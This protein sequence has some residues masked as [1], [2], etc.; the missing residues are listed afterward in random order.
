MQ[1]VKWPVPG[2]P[3]GKL[4]KWGWIYN[5]SSHWAVFVCMLWSARSPPEAYWSLA[6]PVPSIR[7]HLLDLS[8]FDKHWKIMPLEFSLNLADNSPVPWAT[9][10]S[11]RTQCLWRQISPERNMGP[12]SPGKMRGAGDFQPVR[13]TFRTDAQM[14]P[15][16]TLIQ[17]P[18]WYLPHSQTLIVLEE[19][20]RVD[21]C[22]HH[23]SS[24]SSRSIHS[25]FRKRSW[26]I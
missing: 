23:L 3:A 7:F 5:G 11:T 25:P 2:H 24:R 1:A 15:H 18:S 10:V 6:R 9:P 14:P 12:A 8:I 26:L 21:F 19:T 20:Y 13:T 22:S 4:Q 16:L 17:F